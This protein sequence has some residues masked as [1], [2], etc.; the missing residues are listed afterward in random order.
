MCT[1]VLLLQDPQRDAVVKEELKQ[2]LIKMEI[3]IS[4]PSMG[5]AWSFSWHTGK[6]L[7]CLTAPQSSSTTT[8][9][10]LL[11]SCCSSVLQ[12]L[13]SYDVWLEFL[14]VSVGE[15]L[16][17]SL[18]VHTWENLSNDFESRSPWPC[19]PPNNPLSRLLNADQWWIYEVIEV[20][21]WTH[22]MPLWKLEECL[23]CP[24]TFA[25]YCLIFVR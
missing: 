15:H 8:V 19:L 5:M 4:F 25:N 17:C 21:E 20:I 22:Q 6:L 23:A 16:I 2:K 9:W 18:P 12:T 13:R 24:Q 3:P 1:A 10:C 7:W 14:K 11:L